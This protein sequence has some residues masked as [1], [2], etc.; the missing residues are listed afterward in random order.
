MKSLDDDAL[1]GALELLERAELDA[2]LEGADALDPVAAVVF[3][4]SLRSRRNA[5]SASTRAATTP[6]AI[7][8]ALLDPGAPG[9][10]APSGDPGGGP[11]GGPAGGGGVG[12]IA[13]VGGPAAL[14]DCVRSA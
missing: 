6:A 8:F 14:I 7:H 4:S 1:D 13:W 3:L 9:G 11:A 10:G 12:G 2:E 5:I